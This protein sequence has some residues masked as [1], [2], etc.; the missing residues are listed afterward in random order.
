MRLETGK[1]SHFVK[2]ILAK[3][4]PKPEIEA[5]DE[6]ALL[7]GL[8]DDAGLLEVEDEPEEDPATSRKAMLSSIMKRLKKSPA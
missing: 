4:A 3:R 7:E 8:D 6:L 2:A 5:D 1:H